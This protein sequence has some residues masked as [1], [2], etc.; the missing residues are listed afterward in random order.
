MGN[1][2]VSAKAANAAD[3]GQCGAIEIES[4]TLQNPGTEAAMNSKGHLSCS[5]AWTLVH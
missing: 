1:P 5:L 2:E 3:K 4:A